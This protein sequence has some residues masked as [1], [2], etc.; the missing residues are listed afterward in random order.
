M[1]PK[2][3]NQATNAARKC[4][5]LFPQITQHI[6][7]A[8]DI[9]KRQPPLPPMASQVHCDLG[10]KHCVELCQWLVQLH[11]AIAVVGKFLT[12]DVPSLVR[13]RSSQF[14]SWHYS[15]DEIGTQLVRT[16]KWFAGDTSPDCHP[17]D[18][19]RV[20][21]EWRSLSVRLC[22]AASIGPDDSL[23]LEELVATEAY[24]LVVQESNAAGRRMLAV[25]SVGKGRSRK[26]SR[27][28]QRVPKQ[29]SAEKFRKGV[30]TPPVVVDVER[31]QT[32]LL[33]PFTGGTMVFFADRVELCGV[34][35]CSGPRSQTK[36]KVLDHLRKMRADGAFEAYSGEQLAEL[37]GL[38]GG[39][40]STAGV[41]RDLRDDIVERLAT[42]GNTS[43]GR[44]DVILSGGL[45]YRARPPVTSARRL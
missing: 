28:K 43:C 35:F 24:G 17:I 7:Q 15:V 32:Q 4:C 39:E 40:K 30:A 11:E 33:A 13:I 12:P 22:E 3:L 16:I 26:S 45:G 34:N 37:L 21:R 42:A 14:V 20:H 2:A 9:A 6:R 1:P 25:Q 8:S 41:I 27:K 44:Q 38:K 23:A 29:S 5:L 18:D 36:R 31:Q 19:A 10:T